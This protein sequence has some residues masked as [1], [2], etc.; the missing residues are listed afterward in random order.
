MNK[1]VHPIEIKMTTAGSSLQLGSS[2]SN[3]NV[4]LSKGVK[5]D[6]K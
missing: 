4:E 1:E 5:R 2:G 6:S 3:G